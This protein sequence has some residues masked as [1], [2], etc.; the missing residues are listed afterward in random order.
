M[1]SNI[2]MSGSVILVIMN[3]INQLIQSSIGERSFVSSAIY[4]YIFFFLKQHLNTTF[5]LR[6]TKAHRG[7]LL[8]VYMHFIIGVRQ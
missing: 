1:C 3:K 7:G 6:V 4:I 5:A 2:R 8:R